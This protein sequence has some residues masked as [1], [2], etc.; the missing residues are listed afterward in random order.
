MGSSRSLDIY[1]RLASSSLLKGKGICVHNAGI[2][3]LNTA[4]MHDITS[5]CIIENKLYV[6]SLPKIAA[7]AAAP[8]SSYRN[9]NTFDCISR[10]IKKKSCTISTEYYQTLMTNNTIK[11]NQALF[12]MYHLHYFCT[13]GS[14]S[15]SAMD[16]IYAVRR[17]FEKPVKDP[18]SNSFFAPLTAPPS[19]LPSDR[20]KTRVQMIAE[21]EAKKKADKM[22]TRSK[23]KS[24]NEG[25]R[26]KARLNAHKPE[27]HH[28]D[29]NRNN[30]IYEPTD[31]FLLVITTSK[32]N[33]HMQLLNKSQSYRTLFG[34][35]AGNV[36]ITGKYTKELLTATRV[37]ANMA[38]KCRRLG[39]LY[40]HVR[41]RNLKKMDACI[42]GLQLHG[43]KVVSITH[44]PRIPKCSIFASKPRQKRKV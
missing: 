41:F 26:R 9:C 29:R 14:L 40:V 3:S 36:G 2:P 13:G 34:S 17:N 33:V 16:S 11:N 12:N 39:V 1:T 43:L 23:K 31:T 6:T 15:S 19:P 7:A 37:A 30:N 42:K 8:A 5:Q 20:Y 24:K 10:T 21:K 27:F 22:S 18:S 4:S 32:N 25:N 35:H 38:R 28:I 44:E